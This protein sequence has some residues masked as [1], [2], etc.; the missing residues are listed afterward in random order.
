MR[1]VA[2]ALAVPFFIACSASPDGQQTPGGGAFPPGQGALGGTASGTSAGGGAQPGA[3]GGVS[4]STPGNVGGTASAGGG[5]ASGAAAGGG[6]FMECAETKAG[7]ERAARGSNVVWAI[8]TSG[9]M[10]EEAA[11]VQQNLNRFVQAIVMAG[12]EDYRV[13]VISERDFVSVPDPLGSDS[14]HFMHIEEKVSSDESLS[15]M[16]TRFDA[17]S[18]FLLK[19]VVTH[20][21]SVTDDES[22]ITA[23]DF[24]AR[25]QSRL[26]GDFRVH[27]I[28]SPPGDTSATGAGSLF[29]DDDEDTGCQGTYGAAAEAG[30]QHFEAAKLTK[31]LSFSICSED[32]SAL[33]GELAKQVGETATIPCALNLPAA[34]RGQTLDFALVNVVYTKMG[35]SSGEKLPRV[36][37]ASKCSAQGGWH[38]DNEQSPTSIVLCASSCT[39]TAAGGSLDVA[40]G[41][42]SFVY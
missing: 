34:P 17:Y 28:A 23:Q 38:Y 41:C 8:D 16:L 1:R 14:K 12:L 2:F 25:M 24:I 3:A 42:Q 10:D 40:L 5:Q 32:W 36:S 33:F 31:G 20:F 27:A 6:G 11:L 39:A 9:S 7:A 19:G 29:G 4:G 26:N 21:V 15:D 22:E 13:V 30:V 37:D 35:A 18:N